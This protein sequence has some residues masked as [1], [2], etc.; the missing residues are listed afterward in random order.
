ML[1]RCKCCMS[2]SATVILSSAVILTPTRTTILPS[3]MRPPSMT[4]TRTPMQNTQRTI[5]ASCEFLRNVPFSYWITHLISKR[6]DKQESPHCEDLSER[7]F[8]NRGFQK[9]GSIFIVVV[10]NPRSQSVQGNLKSGM[11][12]MRTASRHC[13]SD[14]K[15]SWTLFQALISGI[16][17][18]LTDSSVELI[19][20][21]FSVAGD[22]KGT[23]GTLLTHTHRWTVQSMGFQGLWVWGGKLK[24]EFKNGKKKSEKNGKSSV[25]IT[26]PYV[27][28]I[29][30]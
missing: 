7:I 5:R 19:K 3:T 13:R 9:A 24:I 10:A 17:E 25:F 14:F 29:P 28:S 30:L 8:D 23:V 4:T 1:Y 21:F 20:I 12:S 16:N 26:K 15:P 11:S 6:E 2:S 18:L 22:P 27:Y